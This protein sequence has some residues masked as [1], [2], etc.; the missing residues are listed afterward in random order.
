ML[1]APASI[2]ATMLADLTAGFGEP[3]LG[4]RPNSSCRPVVSASRIIGSPAADTRLGSSKTGV[5]V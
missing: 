4:C 5:T 2:P 1:S 3:T